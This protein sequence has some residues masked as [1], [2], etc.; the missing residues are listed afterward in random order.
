MHASKRDAL[1]QR[2]HSGNKSPEVLRAFDLPDTEAQEHP[3]VVPSVSQ[4]LSIFYSRPK[5]FLQSFDCFYSVP[6]VLVRVSI[7]AQTLWPRSKLGRKGFIQLTLS[8]LLFI[9]K[10][11]GDWNSS[12]S[13]SRSWC[14]GHGG[15]LLTGLLPLACSA[16]S[17]IEPRLPAQGWS[18]PQTSSL[19]H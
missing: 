12:R 9:T 14:R 10:G 3:E 5:C 15:M 11:S 13:G 19:D 16:C 1:R 2:F 17:L 6:S 8:T 18:H 4:K 7:P